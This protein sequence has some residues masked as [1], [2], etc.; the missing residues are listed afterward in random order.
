[1]QP[2]LDLALSVFLKF[3]AEEYD[4]EATDNFKRDIVHNS[5]AIENWVSG[6]NLMFVALDGGKIVGVIG[7]KRSDGHINL[8]FVDGNYHRRGIATA[9]TNLMTAAL[10]ANGFSEITLFSSPHGLPFYKHYGFVPTGATR[11]ED[12]FIFT[13]MRYILN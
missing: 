1:V 9:L 3:E 5:T 13:P 8:L 12:G 7:E 4:P 11:K 10:S 6:K 2:A